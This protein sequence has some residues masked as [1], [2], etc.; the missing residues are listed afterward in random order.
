MDIVQLSLSVTPS[1][2]F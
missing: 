2:Q 1:N